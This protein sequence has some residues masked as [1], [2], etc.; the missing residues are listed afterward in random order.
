ME[1]LKKQLDR[2]S[3]E[4][5][6]PKTSQERV[7]EL[8]ETTIKIAKEIDNHSVIPFAYD[9]IANKYKKESVY[10]RRRVKAVVI[11]LQEYLK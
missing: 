3:V 1:T 5:D 11:L 6:N 4:L 7:K 9:M 2:I 10:P 8:Q